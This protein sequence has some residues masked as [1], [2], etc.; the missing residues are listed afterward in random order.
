MTI[1]TPKNSGIKM[2]DFQSI[3][4]NHY[5]RL[6]QTNSKIKFLNNFMSVKS[7]GKCDQCN[8]KYLLRVAICN[9]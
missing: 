7:V 3:L 1:Y 8:C 4:I 9:K 6:K 5:I 2:S